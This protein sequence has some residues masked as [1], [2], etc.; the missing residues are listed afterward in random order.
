[1]VNEARENYAAAVHGYIFLL[2]TPFSLFELF[3]KNYWRVVTVS[4]K[5]ESAPGKPFLK[6]TTP[7]PPPPSPTSLQKRWIGPRTLKTA[8]RA[9]YFRT[10]RELPTEMDIVWDGA[11]NGDDQD[12]SQMEGNLS[13]PAYREHQTLI[14]GIPELVQS[15]TR[16]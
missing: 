13:G 4:K 11:W 2:L 10:L 9:L 15:R 12:S 6:S 1:M 3:K 16:L 8:P 5:I 14:K 7:P